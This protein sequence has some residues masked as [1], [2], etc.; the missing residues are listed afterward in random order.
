MAAIDGGLWV[1]LNVRGELARIEMATGRVTA[2]IDVP[3]H[4]FEIAATDD[5]LW[6]TT[7][8]G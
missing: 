4:P 5:R 7:D 6:V 8:E 1:A 3:G 2:H